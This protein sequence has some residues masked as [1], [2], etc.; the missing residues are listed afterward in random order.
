MSYKEKVDVNE[1]VFYSSEKQKVNDNN[2]T[3][4]EQPLKSRYDKISVAA[5]N[6]QYKYLPYNQLPSS[7]NKKINKEKKVDSSADRGMTYSLPPFGGYIDPRNET[8]ADQ[9]L[10]DQNNIKQFSKKKTYHH[11]SMESPAKVDNNNSAQNEQPLKSK[12]DKVSVATRN[13]QYEYLPY[14]QLPSSSNKKI[15]VKRKSNSE[16]CQ[17]YDHRLRQGSILLKG[18]PI[19]LSPGIQ[20]ATLPHYSAVEVSSESI[21]PLHNALI[22]GDRKQIHKLI[23]S[24]DDINLV[25]ECGMTPLH[26]AAYRGYH[27]VC[28]TLLKKGSLCSIKTKNNYMALHIAALRG[29]PKVCELLIKYNKVVDIPTKQVFQLKDK[30]NMTTQSYTALHLAA[31]EGHADVVEVLLK[32]KASPSLSTE[33]FGA[34][35]DLAAR[36]GHAEVCQLLLE[37]KYAVNPNR[38]SKETGLTALHRAI[39]GNHRQICQLLL[40]N[41]ADAQVEGWGKTP[42]DY[43]AGLGHK[44]I[45]EPLLDKKYGVDIH[46]ASKTQR[47]TALHYAAFHGHAGVCE[48]LLKSGAKVDAKAAQD[49]TPLHYAALLKNSDTCNVLLNNFANGMAA[50][51]DGVTPLHLAAK[52]GSIDVARRL[53]DAGAYVN[54]KTVQGRTPLH[55]AATFDYSQVCKLLI[56]HSADVD[57]K[58]IYETTP[59]YSAVLN[60]RSIEVV[61]TLI[62]GGADVTYKMSKGSGGGWTALH[63]AA[64]LGLFDICKTLIYHR[65]PINAC[66]DSGGTPLHLAAVNNR[67]DVAI[68][69]LS[70]GAD[71][72]IKDKNGNTPLA[73]AQIIIDADQKLIDALQRF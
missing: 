19:K 58:D 70:Y 62:G 13:G 9:P 22:A 44:K 48:L 59:L 8:L 51:T 14:E 28:K 41:G 56:K 3:Q 31:A 69:L 72:S 5:R 67:L 60:K 27:D 40:E 16:M 61:N 63:C 50:T 1:M 53:L 6:G 55:L 49:N 37:R 30:S 2:S 12:Y 25:D 45:C 21:I 42:L 54:S 52:S 20:Q 38:V 35:L 24:I 4:N 39:I 10:P 23:E 46:H 71:K 47:H 57:A 36:N 17:V 64:E 29:H 33:N 43:T 7:S 66:A 26:L 34:A 68:F 65:A 73:L 15:Q 32:Y 11:Y 18:V